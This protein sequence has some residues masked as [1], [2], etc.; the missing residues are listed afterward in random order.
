MSNKKKNNYQIKYY[1]IYFLF[2]SAWT[3]LNLKFFFFDLTAKQTP[4]SSITSML[5]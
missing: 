3:D 2:M 1:E 4:W 5:S